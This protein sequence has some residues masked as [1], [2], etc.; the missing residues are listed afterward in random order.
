MRKFASLLILTSLAACQAEPEAEQAEMAGA[1]DAVAEAADPA[2]EAAST[3]PAAED[4]DKANAEAI[5]S[6]RETAAAAA[7]G[8]ADKAI[9]ACKVKNG[10]TLAVCASDDGKAEYRYGGDKP[11]LVLSGGSWASVPYSGGGEQQIRFTSGDTSYIV[12][13]RMIRTSF[14]PGKPNEP[15]ISDGVIVLRGEKFQAMQLC[16]D[17]SATP[18]NYDAAERFLAPAEGL[19]TEETIRADPDD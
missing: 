14:D 11:E 2:K 5:D 1:P 15:A 7:C 3:D 6:A 4:A 16:N 18:V 10:K 9:F 8:S 13:S 12:F 17:A 19:F